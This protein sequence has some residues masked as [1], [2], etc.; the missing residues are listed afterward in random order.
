[1]KIWTCVSSPRSGPRNAWMR[2]KNV[3]GASVWAK[4]GIFSAP[5]KWF[6]VAIGDLEETW[7]SQYDPATKQQSVEWRHIGSPR[8]KK[9]RVR[10]SAGKVLASIL[11]GIKTA[12][13]SLIIFQRTKLSTWSITHLCWCNWRTFWRRNTAGMSPSGSCIC[14][15]MPGSPGTCNPEETGLPELPL[16]WSPTL[17]SGSG[18]DG[19]QPIPWTERTIELS[20]FFVRRGGHSCRRDVAVRTI[21][22]F[23]LSVLQKLEQRAKKYIELRGE[24]VE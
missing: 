8:P 1:M 23:F 13:S 12:S 9:F 3:N 22:W 18:P 6:P 24:Y 7:L 16:S 11:L 14:T 19:L 17:F 5:S 21:F 4:F 15:T 20:P 10:K 2:I